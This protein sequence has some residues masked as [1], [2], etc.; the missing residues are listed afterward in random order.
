EMEYLNHSSDP[1]LLKSIIQGHR[2]ASVFID[3]IQRLP[4]MLT[5]IQA[6][7]D[8]EQTIQ[9]YLTGSSARK[10]K[11]GGANLLPGRMIN[12]YMGPLIS[13]ECDYKMDTQR[14]LEFGSLP[15]IYTSENKKENIQILKS[16]SA[17]YIKEEIKAEAL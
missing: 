7:I 13:K 6:I 3:E 10:L 9:F 17:N 4:R 15:G 16:Y 12:F 5:S 8:Q 2:P 1:G 11:R 14:V